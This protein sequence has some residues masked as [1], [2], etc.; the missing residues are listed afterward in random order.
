MLLLVTL[1][2]TFRDIRS[3]NDILVFG[4]G[5]KLLVF[6]AAIAACWAIPTELNEVDDVDVCV[7]RHE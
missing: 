5:A 3:S 7:R 1:R 4:A 2:R 6:A